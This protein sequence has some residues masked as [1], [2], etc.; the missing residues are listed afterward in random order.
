MSNVKKKEKKK[1]TEEKVGQDLASPFCDAR[2]ARQ[3][4]RNNRGLLLCK[5]V[6]HL[7]WL[8]QCTTKALTATRRVPCNMCSVVR[9][10]ACAAT[11][12]ASNVHSSFGES[13][14]IA[15]TAATRARTRLGLCV[16]SLI[17]FITFNP[18]SSPSPCLPRSTFSSAQ[19]SASTVF[20]VEC[21]I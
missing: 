1:P 11:V 13:N 3:A 8:P 9:L 6:V 14:L 5:Y 7:P 16:T 12:T 19:Q 15:Q 18:A 20:P 2:L 21:A 4:W 10:G 17:L